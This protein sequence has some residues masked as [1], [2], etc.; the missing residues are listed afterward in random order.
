MFLQPLLLAHGPGRLQGLDD[1]GGHALVEHA[2]QEFPAGREPSRAVEHLDISAEG[3]EDGS[4]ARGAGSAG[5]HRNPQAAPGHRG[6]HRYVGERDVCLFGEFSQLPFGARRGRVQV[7]PKDLRPR[8]L[9]LLPAL[10]VFSS[11]RSPASPA[12]K[13]STAAFALLTLSTK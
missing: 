12:L 6:H 11:W 7:G 10:V 8:A 2:A 1:R 9:V 5:Q 4:V 3:L 13:A